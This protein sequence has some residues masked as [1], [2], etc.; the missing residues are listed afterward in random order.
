MSILLTNI[1]TEHSFLYYNIILFNNFI[2]KKKSLKYIPLYFLKES[3]FKIIHLYVLIYR[4]PC[5]RIRFFL[6]NDE[7]LITQFLRGF[8]RKRLARRAI[9]Q[10][11]FETDSELRRSWGNIGH[12]RHRPV[13]QRGRA[14]ADVAAG[15]NSFRPLNVFRPVIATN[16]C[17]IFHRT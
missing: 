8:V 11:R 6:I 15:Y 4:F 13:F 16:R 10:S 17:D 1:F 9:F 12:F 5:P 14:C 7:G 3:N 2:R